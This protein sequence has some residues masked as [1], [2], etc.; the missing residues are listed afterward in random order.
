MNVTGLACDSSYVFITG[1]LSGVEAVRTGSVSYDA[2]D[3]VI[4]PDG[5]VIDTAENFAAV[6][7][8]PEDTANIIIVS[9]V[10]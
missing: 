5:S 9:A 8:L 3:P 7:S 1:D 4:S 10:D 2:A 6:T